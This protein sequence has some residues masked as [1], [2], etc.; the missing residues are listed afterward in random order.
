VRAEVRDEGSSTVESAS[1]QQ[2]VRPVSPAPPLPLSCPEAALSPGLNMRPDLYD[3][4]SYYV[5]RAAY[6]M[7]PNG[8]PNRRRRSKSRSKVHT[9]G[10]SQHRPNDMI[11]EP[12]YGTSTAAG[13]THDCAQTPGQYQT[14]KLMERVEQLQR[15]MESLNHEVTYYR[16]IEPHRRDFIDRVER[17]GDDLKNALFQLGKIQ[18]QIDHEWIQSRQG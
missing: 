2:P 8:Q 5:F 6:F 1:Y 17:A 14:P 11:D 13:A 3:P 16:Q 18:R 4:K 9:D 12:H 7:S 10:P 15:Q